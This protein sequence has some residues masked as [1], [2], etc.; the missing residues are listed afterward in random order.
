MWWL[1]AKEIGETDPVELGMGGFCFLVAELLMEK[2]PDAELCR[3]TDKDRTTFA[4][5]FVRIDGRPCDIK[6][7]RSLSAIREDRPEP[8]LVEEP[9][10]VESVQMFFHARYDVE[11]LAAARTVLEQYLASKRGQP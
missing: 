2:Y 8:G 1:T 11:L 7:F 3:L 10:S 4:H 5:V 9:V 6:G